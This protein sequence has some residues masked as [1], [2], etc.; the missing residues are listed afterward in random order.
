M[1]LQ[2]D[3]INNQSRVVSIQT[4]V[5]AIHQQSQFDPS[6]VIWK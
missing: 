5:V 4:E 3:K 2:S 1:Q 6:K